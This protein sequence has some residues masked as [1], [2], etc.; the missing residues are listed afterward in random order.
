MN[1]AR[2]K[3]IEKAI[4][5]LQQIFADLEACR[6]EEQE[7]FDG[8]PEGERGQQSEAAISEL[9]SAIGDIE[10]VISSLETAKE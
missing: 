6:D 7:A 9:D 1:N 4:G 2:R 3:I 8:M 10:N 5:D